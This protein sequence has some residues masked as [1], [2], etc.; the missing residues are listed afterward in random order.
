MMI[1]D[2]S[3]YLL[4]RLLL[5]SCCRHPLRSEGSVKRDTGSEEGAREQGCPASI[6]SDPPIHSFDR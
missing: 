4:A 6:Y 2:L 5:R 1:L 3:V